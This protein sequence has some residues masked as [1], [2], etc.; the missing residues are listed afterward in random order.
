MDLPPE[1][2]CRIAGGLDDLKW[3]TSAR[4]AC[5][6]WRRTLVPPSPSLLI[7]HG[8]G[9]LCP[10]ARRSF[11][12]TTIPLARTCLGCCSGWLAL[13]ICIDGIRS[14]LNLFH[15]ITAVEILLPLL[16]YDSRLVSK[17]VFAPNPATDDFVATVICD[18]DRVAYITTGARRWS[19]LDPIRLTVRDQLIDLLYHEN[20]RVYF[21]TR[22]G[23]VHVLFLP[24]RHHPEPIILEVDTSAYPA[25]HNRK[26]IQMH[27][28]R[29]DLSAPATI[30]ALLSSMGSNLS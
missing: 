25:V 8:D 6:T 4:G 3:Y 10:A 9:K 27:G 14:L 28:T 21:L 22:F 29:P 19:V 26:I 18:I 15:P 24:Q 11:K 2:V 12:L 23:D 13:S 17:I 20:G 16:V 30:K 5:T 7:D 1:L